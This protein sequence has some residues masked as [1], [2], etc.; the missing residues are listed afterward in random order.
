MAHAASAPAL[1]PVYPGAALQATLDLL[2]QGV[3]LFD[4]ALCLVAWNRPFEQLLELPPWMCFRG[5]PCES[6]IA[7]GA[8][9]GA[10]GPGDPGEQVRAMVARARTATAH[11]WLRTRPD[12]SVLQVQARPI[13]G[14][15]LALLYSD[16][17]RC[18]HGGQQALE[19]TMTLEALVAER[20]AELSRSEAR[21]RLITDSV[22]ALIA[23]FDR[24]RV[25]HFINR[26][27]AEWFGLDTSRPREV[28]AKAYLGAATYAGIRHNVA[29]ALHGETV[30][31]EYD[32]QLVG[33]RHAIAQTTLIPEIGDDGSVLGCFE[34][35]IDTAEQKRAQKLIVEAQKMEALGQLTGGLAHDF[36]N[37]LT[38]IIGNLT[39]LAELGGDRAEI[40]EYVAPAVHAARRGSE[41]IKGLLSFSRRQPLDARAVEIAPLLDAVARFVQPSLPDDL[42]LALGASDARLTCWTDSFQ[43]QNALLNLVFN[44]RDAMPAGGEV[45]LSAA[46]EVVDDAA[47]LELDVAAGRYVRIQIDDDGCG[48]DQATLA[49]ACEPLFTTKQ[50]GLGTGLGLAMVQGFVRQSGGAMRMHS[51][52]GAGTRVALL[53]PAAH[54]AES[55]DLL[56]PA[57]AQ[58]PVD[59]ARLALLVDDDADVRKVVRRLLLGLGYAV[60]EAE[61][62]TEAVSILDSTP[63][64]ALLLSDVVMPGDIDGVE[65]AGYAE[66]CHAIPRIILMSGHA[67]TGRQPLRWP[68]L[69]KP[70]AHDDLVAIL[71][72][73]RS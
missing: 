34:L 14:F 4:S 17:T 39:A 64:V 23:Y 10:Y 8:A 43:L 45:R 42:R 12:G 30:T 26:G 19:Q 59:P 46:A 6:F 47:A 63:G 62:A 41:L 22:P 25:Y 20:T 33:G 65:L 37:I 7:Y 9:R 15:G 55:D 18:G 32:A 21:M 28:S 61:S 35:T 29:R 51:A 57:A 24:T 5:A 70:F 58:V 44:A 52:P 2:E 36:N 49:R 71:S 1:E 72:S 66:R 27:Y 54:S 13:P 56:A 11:D 3:A 48:M 53:I 38:V 68:L 67:P 31:F 60:I 69:G 16:V 40:D 73:E 50:V